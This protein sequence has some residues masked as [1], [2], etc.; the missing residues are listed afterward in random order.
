M[1]KICPQC[2]IR[3][4]DEDTVCVNCGK[5]F[6]KQLQP[7]KPTAKNTHPWRR[8][9]ARNFDYLLFGL[10][11]ALILQFTYPAMLAIDNMAFGLLLIFIWI[12]VESFL[13]SAFGT[14]PGKWIF[15]ISLQN[16]DGT[17]LAF[18]NALTRSFKV[19]FFGLAAGFPFITVVTQLVA[20]HKLVKTGKTSWDREGNF[21]VTHEKI[22]FV[23]IFFVVLLFLIYIFLIGLSQ[24]PQTPTG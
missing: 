3:L 8:F 10:L 9:F 11:F 20:R 22:S 5:Q 16:P 18:S 4:K 24:L 12:F 7:E 13:L 6:P 23:R 21:K 1:S 14:T 17:K 19:W 15:N 2:N